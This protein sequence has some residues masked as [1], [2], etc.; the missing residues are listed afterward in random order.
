[1]TDEY[2][3]L[4][5]NVVTVGQ[6]GEAF[7]SFEKYKIFIESLTEISDNELKIL[8]EYIDKDQLLLIINEEKFNVKFNEGYQWFDENVIEKLNLAIKL[9]KFS[10]KRFCFIEPFGMAEMDQCINLA[11]IDKE[12]YDSLLE[13]S[14]AEDLNRFYHF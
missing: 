7:E 6:D 14:Y 3:I 5:R 2:K 12:L 4:N 11:F 8:V 1:M 13:N 10:E 9:H